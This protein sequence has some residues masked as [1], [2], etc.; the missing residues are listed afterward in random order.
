[1]KLSKT[2]FS[3]ILGQEKSDEEIKKLIPNKN[4]GMSDLYDNA[5]FLIA[6]VRQLS[7]FSHALPLSEVK[8]S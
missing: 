3:C 2:P 1:M 7:F 8:A 4:M 6:F 5:Q